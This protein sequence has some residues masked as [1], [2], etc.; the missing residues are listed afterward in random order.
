MNDERGESMEPK[1]EVSL[2]GQCVCVLAVQPPLLSTPEHDPF[3]SEPFDRFC[4]Y[5]PTTSE[6]GQSVLFFYPREILATFTR[7]TLC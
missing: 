7:A 3:L 6:D 2:T 4:I 5:Q 1:E